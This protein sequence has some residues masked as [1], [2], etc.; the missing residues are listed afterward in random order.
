MMIHLTDRRVLKIRLQA[1]K[2]KIFI[3]KEKNY[4]LHLPPGSL[5]T[6]YSADYADVN[7]GIFGDVLSQNA[8][9]IT[10][11]LK[12]HFSDFAKGDTGFIQNTMD[13]YK[14]IGKD[15]NIFHIFYI[16]YKL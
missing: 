2:V 1:M 9:Q 14:N 4:I 16:I 10:E 13:M 12:E 5:K 3:Q 7:L 11:D 6:Q 15:M 8:F